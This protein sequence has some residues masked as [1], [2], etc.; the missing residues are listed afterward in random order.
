MDVSEYIEGTPLTFLP[1]E[2]LPPVTKILSKGSSY[3]KFEIVGT[4]VSIDGQD[5]LEVVSIALKRD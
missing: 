2:V 4:M 3:S 1:S 5:Y